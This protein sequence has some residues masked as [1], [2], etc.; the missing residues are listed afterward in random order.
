MATTTPG[1]YDTTTTPDLAGLFGAII[2]KQVDSKTDTSQNTADNSSSSSTGSQNV[3]GDTTSIRNDIGNQTTV[4]ST[5]SNTSGLQTSTGKQTQT[6][7][8]VTSGTQRTTGSTTNTSNS[9]TSGSSS[10]SVNADTTAL[11][12][13]YAKQASG[14][15]A[16][17]LAAIF[18]QGSKAAPGM[19]TAQSNAMGARAVGNTPVA[20]ALNQM[21]V[22]LTS[23]AADINRQLLQDSGNTA[24]KIADMTKTINKSY[25]E[26]TS[27]V[28]KS[29][30]DLLTATDSTTLTK[31]IV[32]SINNTANSSNTHGTSTNTVDTTNS[33][34][35]SATSNQ[36]TATTGATTANRNQT[37]TGT[38]KKGV[39]TTINT[40]MAKTLLGGLAAG[41]GIDTL[42][43]VATGKGFVGTITDFAKT[44]VG[45]GGSQQQINNELVKAG[46]PILDSGSPSDPPPLDLGDPT[47]GFTDP[48]GDPYTDTPEISLDPEFDYSADTWDMGD[49]WA[50]GGVPAAPFLQV[51]DLFKQPTV[52]SSGDD[53]LSALLQQLTKSTKQ[54]TTS[55]EGA[56]PGGVSAQGP[57]DG[58][59]NAEGGGPGSTGN[60]TSATP[61]GDLGFTAMPGPVASVI[62]AMTG[63]PIGMINSLVG[64]IGAGLNAVSPTNPSGINAVNGMDSDSDNAVGQSMGMIGAIASAMGIPIGVAPPSGVT[65][66]VDG[67][68]GVAVSSDAQGNTVGVDGPAGQGGSATGDGTAGSTDGSSAAGD[69]GASGSANASGDM[70]DGGEVEDFNLDGDDDSPAGQA[71][72]LDDGGDEEMMQAMGITK[73]KE[74]GLFFNNHALKMMQHALKGSN[75]APGYANGGKMKAKGC[76]D[77]GQIKGPGTGTS[78]SIPALAGNN[79][80]PI[81]VANGEYIIPADVVAK[82]GAGTFDA[83]VNQF[84]TPVN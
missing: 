80:R 26:S 45:S 82:F 65:T 33:S 37:S 3:R 16:E 40:D 10:E 17:M 38:E 79:A 24:G 29:V 59:A 18:Q 71:A 78:D 47:A 41:I 48:T 66:S 73:G 30:Q 49:G 7:S 63:L 43:K 77:G 39:K 44:L 56:T 70:A 75:K 4:G 31:S 62:G 22:D 19:V 21:N 69:S 13:V 74:G 23:K 55:G 64:M 2:G 53:G 6:G 1:D 60:T 50:D 8:N 76:A 46:F 61:S 51:P 34:A 35:A 9:S 5:D 27:S 67:Q 12:D 58:I 15:T 11:R 83:L 68:T 36:D 81:H 54:S 52:V 25:S 14:I 84:H 42:F 32:D 57:G 28:T 72:G 20:Q